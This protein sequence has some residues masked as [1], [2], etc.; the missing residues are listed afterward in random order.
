MDNPTEQIPKVIIGSGLLSLLVDFVMTIVYSFCVV[1]PEDM[2]NPYEG[3]PLIQLIFDL[4]RLK[5]LTA[6]DS[7]LIIAGFLSRERLP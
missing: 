3:Q 7:V 2:L 4:A 5:A 1:N 6:I